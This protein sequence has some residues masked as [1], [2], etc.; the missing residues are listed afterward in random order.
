MPLCSPA[1]KEIQQTPKRLAEQM[2]KAGKGHSLAS[3]NEWLWAT[4]M[5]AVIG[6]TCAEQYARCEMLTLLLDAV[7]APFYVAYAHANTHA[8]RRKYSQH[9]NI[10]VTFVFPPCLLATWLYIRATLFRQ[11]A[12]PVLFD[13]IERKRLRMS[14]I[15]REQ[16]PTFLVT[17]VLAS[18]HPSRIEEANEMSCVYRERGN[19][20]LRNLLARTLCCGIPLATVLHVPT[21]S[22]LLE[23][24]NVVCKKR[25]V[26]EEDAPTRSEVWATIKEGRS[27]SKRDGTDLAT[28]TQFGFDSDDEFKVRLLR[29]VQQDLFIKYN[30]VSPCLC[31]A[32]PRLRLA[33]RRLASLFLFLLSCTLVVCACCC[34]LG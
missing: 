25:S 29:L 11:G 26:L 24:F 14:G 34:T 28:G 1:A 17:L 18:F 2:K 3:S 19:G 5:C 16:Y 20:Q 6:D 10:T 23:R 15:Q 30:L 32:S 12:F 7:A 31:A 21:K 27:T 13:R 8:L 4:L 9:K 22:E 33:R